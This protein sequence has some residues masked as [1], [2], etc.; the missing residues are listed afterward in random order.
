MA[1]PEAQANHAH[2]SAD[3][4]VINSGGVEIIDV[5]EEKTNKISR[6]LKRA[7]IEISPKNEQ[8]LSQSSNKEANAGVTNNSL[9]TDATKMMVYIH[10][11]LEIPSN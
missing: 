5:D 9:V 11:N 2:I 8:V 6:T 10:V 7:R 3:N 1:V 4:S